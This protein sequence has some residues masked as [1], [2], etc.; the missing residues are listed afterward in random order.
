MVNYTST[1]AHM[2]TDAWRGTIYAD[3]AYL[4]DSVR[5]IMLL[6]NRGTTATNG[7]PFY[8]YAS[9]LDLARARGKQD[10]DLNSLTTGVKGNVGDVRINAYYQYGR[11]KSVY[12]HRLPATA[13]VCTSRSD[14]RSK[15]GGS[16]R[17]PFDAHESERRL[18]AR[19]LLRRRHDVE[20]AIDYILDGDMWRKS[21]LQQH[22]A[23]VSADTMFFKDRAAGPLAVAAGFSYPRRLV[24]TVSRVRTI[25]SR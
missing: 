15:S 20:Q 8:R 16:D 23:E 10:N 6:E 13:I 25:S 3:N 18:R 1:G 12:R 11:R 5:Q 9:Q 2:E 7:V 4:P 14:C 17:V 19:Q 22:F 24:P 21:T